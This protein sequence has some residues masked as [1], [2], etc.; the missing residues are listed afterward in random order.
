ME[1]HPTCLIE[2]NARPD[3]T[4]EWLL[5]VFVPR[6]RKI[7]AFVHVAVDLTSTHRLAGLPSLGNVV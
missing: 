1:D 2:Y 5:G 7:G 6:G 4:T 3:S